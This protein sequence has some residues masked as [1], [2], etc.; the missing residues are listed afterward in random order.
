[1]K[2][3]LKVSIKKQLLLIHFYFIDN[4]HRFIY[5][6]VLLFL[7]SYLLAFYPLQ[8]KRKITLPQ[9]ILH[10]KKVQKKFQLIFSL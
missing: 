8:P 4:K 2:I 3:N 9:M 5:L 1:M 10:F 7:K 6:L